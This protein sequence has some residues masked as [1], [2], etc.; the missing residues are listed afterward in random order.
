MDAG[1][2]LQEDVLTALSKALSQLECHQVD[3]LAGVEDDL[4]I[5]VEN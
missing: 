4:Q 5:G 2:V 3:E 1:S